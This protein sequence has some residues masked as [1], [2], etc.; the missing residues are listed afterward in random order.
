MPLSR[1]A[2]LLTNDVIKFK[3]KIETPLFTQTL[4]NVRVHD[5]TVIRPL[6]AC[7]LAYLLAHTLILPHT[8]TTTTILTGGWQQAANRGCKGRLPE[9]S[10]EVLCIE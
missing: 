4:A 3:S 1:D 10:A 7:L 2:H 6:L 5:V 8:T 9:P